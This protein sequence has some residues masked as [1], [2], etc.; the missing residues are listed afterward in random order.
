MNNDNKL[1]NNISFEWASGSKFDYPQDNLPDEGFLGSLKS[2][3]KAKKFNE[4]QTGV[5]NFSSAAV[6]ESITPDIFKLL[7]DSYN[8]RYDTRCNF[9]I[10]KALH[11]NGVDSSLFNKI[12]SASA[13]LFG[14]P[15]D[16]KLAKLVTK[17]AISRFNQVCMT[18]E[19]IKS[20]VTEVREQSE[21]SDENCKLVKRFE[22]MLLDA[23]KKNQ[24]METI[25]DNSYTEAIANLKA[26]NKYPIKEKLQAFLENNDFIEVLK[27]CFYDGENSA[28]MWF[29]ICNTAIYK[30]L[31]NEIKFRKSKNLEASYF[32][33]RT[34]NEF[35]PD[36]AAIEEKQ[37]TNQI[38]TCLTTIIDQKIKQLEQY[39]PGKECISKNLYIDTLNLQ[40]NMI[41]SDMD[42]KAARVK[43]SEISSALSEDE[44]IWFCETLIRVRDIEDKLNT[45]LGQER[46]QDK[47]NG[48]MIA[49]EKSVFTQ[50][51]IQYLLK[52]LENNEALHLLVLQGKMSEN[53]STIFPKNI[54]VVHGTESINAMANVF[55]ECELSRLQFF[56]DCGY[57]N[58]PLHFSECGP[59]ISYRELKNKLSKQATSLLIDEHLNN[60]GVLATAVN[61]QIGE[62][63]FIINRRTNPIISAGLV[64]GIMPGDLFYLGNA[65]AQVTA[66]DWYTSTLEIVAEHQVD[67]QE[68]QYQRPR[69]IP[70]AFFSNPGAIQDP[71]AVLKNFILERWM[72]SLRHL[73]IHHA[74]LHTESES[75]TLA[76]EKIFTVEM[77][78]K[79]IKGNLSR[80][81]TLKELEKRTKEEFPYAPDMEVPVH[82]SRRL[83]MLFKNTGSKV[84]RVS[85]DV[86]YAPESEEIMEGYL[87]SKIWNNNEILHELSFVF[88]QDSQEQ[89]SETAK[90]TF[91][92]GVVFANA[93]SKLDPE[94]VNFDFNRMNQPSQWRKSTVNF[95]SSPTVTNKFDSTAY[96]V[97]FIEP[98]IDSSNKN[99]KN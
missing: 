64:H 54:A 48:H 53:L 70:P 96:M 33:G 97:R 35:T 52:V 44:N 31:F 92:A 65:I 98:N 10:P 72:Q 32:I 19:S 38:I 4:A 86:I 56:A 13:F 12:E 90:N 20:F 29:T 37:S 78:K 28:T 77:T 67:I 24:N 61:K 42:L 30:H 15:T 76:C 18:S 5:V 62:A 1:N 39:F 80:I 74:V 43:L 6:S 8:C 93:N 73:A 63:K 34:Y 50:D 55:E 79:E 94:T 9:E 83:F 58:E 47:K 23:S 68:L 45:K 7:T 17:V 3:M 2:I 85:R 71:P 81:R 11:E 87:E 95:R 22:K 40:R 69:L 59:T 16:M 26:Y 88:K 46:K 66:V 41:N 25:F 51:D 57:G 75:N 82:G 27:K 21:A 99:M 91:I 84:T 49:L 60:A 36:I 89:Y 14:D